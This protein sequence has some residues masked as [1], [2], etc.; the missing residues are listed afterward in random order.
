[1]DSITRD[2]LCPITLE[3]LDDPVT[4]PCCG[5]ACG[6]AALCTWLASEP[7]CP[8]CRDDLSAL[9]VDALPRNRVLAGMV[10]TVRA[11]QQAALAAAAATVAARPSHE[12]S[13][14]LER[15]ADPASELVRATVRITNSKFAARK[16]LFIPIVDRSGS[17]QGQPWNQVEAALLHIVA[18]ARSSNGG[19]DT[20]IIAYS[21]EA[22]FY[23]TEGDPSAVTQMIKRL[24]TGGGTNFKAAFNTLVEVLKA[25]GVPLAA[26]HLS[27]NRPLP[28]CPYG[29]I[30]VAFLTDGQDSTNRTADV[31]AQILREGLAQFDFTTV[32]L[33]VHAMGFSA[34]CDRVLLEKIRESGPVPGTFRFAEPGDGDDALASKMSALLQFSLEGSTVPITLALRGAEFAPTT[35]D[36]KTAET[37]R[38]FRIPISFADHGGQIKV[39]LKIPPQPDAQLRSRFGLTVTSDVDQDRDI[40]ASASVQNDS[41]DLMSDWL[42]LQLDIMAQELINLSE[43]A[44]AGSVSAVARELQCALFQRRLHAI[45]RL[46]EDPRIAVFSDQLTKIMT[47]QRVNLGKLSDLRFASQFG[48]PDSKSTAHATSTYMTSVPAPPLPPAAAIV[49]KAIDVSEKS[50]RLSFNH[51]NFNRTPLQCAILDLDLKQP[52]AKV[53]QLIDQAAIEDVSTPDADGNT[54]VHHAAY[55]GQH[56]LLE[57]IIKRFGSLPS[58]NAA[59]NRGETPITL[60]IKRRGFTKTIQVILDSPGAEFPASRVKQLEQYCMNHKYGRCAA[61]MASFGSPSTSID[62]SMS[63]DYIEFQYLNVVKRGVAFDS[64]AWLEIAMFKGMVSLVQRLLV[65]HGAKAEARWLF[66]YGFPPKVADKQN[67]AAVAQQYVDLTDAVLAAQPELLRARLEESGDTLLHRAADRGSLLHV[68]Y[69]ADRLG[70]S[71]LDERNTLGNTPFWLAC[72]KRYPDIAEELMLRGCDTNAANK[73]GNVPLSNIC[74]FGPVAMAETLLAAGAQLTHVN[75]NGDTLILLAVRNGQPDV[76]KLFLNYADPD[77]VAFKAHIDGF[78]AMFAAVEG[79][80]TTCIRVLHEHG[81]SVNQRTAVDNAIIADATPLHLAA[82][83]GRVASLRLLLEL[84]ADVDALD[85]H[86][87]TPLHIAVIRG[88]ASAVQQLREANANDGLRDKA[89]NRAVSYCRDQPAIRAA[90]VDPLADVLLSWARGQLSAKESEECA[91]ILRRGSSIPCAVTPAT[92]LNVRGEDGSIPA[93]DAI[94]YSNPAALALLVELMGESD[95]AA[96][97]DQYGLSPLFWAQWIKQPRFA[98]LLPGLPTDPLPTTLRVAAEAQASPINQSLLFLTDPPKHLVGSTQAAAA[99]HCSK[100]SIAVRMAAFANHVTLPSEGHASTATRAA[101]ALLNGCPRQNVALALTTHARKNA[102]TRGDTIEPTLVE[103]VLWRAKVHAIATIAS[104]ASMADDLTVP[105]RYALHIFSSQPATALALGA[106]VLGAGENGSGATGTHGG[107]AVLGAHLLDAITALPGYAGEVFV[108][109]PDLMRGHFTPGARVC[110]GTFSSGSTMWPVATAALGNN[111][112]KS[113]TILLIQSKC[114]GKLIAPF[115]AFSHD[116]E[117]VFG[118]QCAFRVTNWYRGDVIALGQANIRQ[119]TFGVTSQEELERLCQSNKPLIIE[120]FEEDV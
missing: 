84:G 15:S 89:G 87:M 57:A 120:L 66:D 51:A 36:S 109:V 100:S 12:W 83:Y 50:Y 17:M 63:T 119:H 117:V 14:D 48:G 18:A 43:V 59:N 90:L 118:P 1:M 60:A 116:M 85:A 26:A 86:G 44:S 41:K 110:W 88:H 68:Q 6:R 106:F 77:L 97:S 76:L 82:Y 70:P 78:N 34:S 49:P 96:L 115:S 65:E 80:R 114:H 64:N 16:A 108:G 95:V 33:T 9:D 58:V 32:P 93:V 69:Y 24:F 38:T 5:K 62:A 45:R 61:L 94:L 53:L 10:D 2:L 31:L 21:S 81:V 4:L 75:N 74:Q 99:S 46:V 98:K 92:M 55:C 35:A 30:A 22:Q 101:A 27:S 52:T 42:R 91:A 28:P 11:Q 25:S 112:A 73:K 71:G 29:S 113:G 40:A 102:L 37:V 19:V 107:V 8:L 105:Q 111:F 67:A 3:L 20:K 79:D 39:W 103:E 104:K 47:N 72:A 56:R 23:S 7:S 13:V 54:A